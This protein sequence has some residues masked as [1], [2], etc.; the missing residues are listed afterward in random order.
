MQAQRR[1]KEAQI[2]EWQRRNNFCR[3][4]T[5]GPIFICSCCHRRL[6]ENGVT[7]I[8]EK[9]KEKLNGTKNVPYSTVIPP[10]QERYVR[11]VLDGSSTLSGFYICHTCK[12]SLLKGKLPAMAVQNG[13]QLT[14]LDD[15][16]QLT[17]LENNLIAQ[18]INFQY[19]YQLPKSR[20]GATK[21]QM[22]SVPVSQD[23]VRE[24][25]EQLPRLPKDAGLIAVDL[26]RKMGYSNSHKKEMIDP[27][28][29]MRVLQI[30][31]ESGHPYY[32]FC[33]D[34]NS[35]AY[36]DRCREEDKQGYDLLFD[37]D[38]LSIND[39][40]NLM[41]SEVIESDDDDEEEEVD[42]LA[43][44]LDLNP[45]EYDIHKEIVRIRWDFNEENN[46]II[47]IFKE[48]GQYIRVTITPEGE[49][50]IAATEIGNERDLLHEVNF[51]LKTLD[52]KVLQMTR[53]REN[54]NPHPG[55][56]VH[57]A[58]I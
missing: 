2:N 25:I 49:E 44:A 54:G 40:D 1:K 21:K 5:F 10:E 27:E 46:C 15:D 57:H 36:K 43:E 17:E 19:I 52:M 7:K 16:C 39:S 34:F 37:L 38:K 56:L 13:L 55:V 48:R 14:K 18:V 53:A 28:K 33:D 6:F 42:T 26:K 58:Y 22:I 32:Q 20:W 47:E 9:F 45:E 11:I 3:A 23:T 8:T 41:N 4:V 50:E 51:I 29:I 24:T 30:L 12:G 31:K 35:D